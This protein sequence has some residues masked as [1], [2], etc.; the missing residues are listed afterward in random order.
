MPDKAWKAFER[1]IAK[2]LGTHR[3]PLSG[4]ASRHTTSDTLHE[5]LYVEC[6]SRVRSAIHKWWF[7]VRQSALKEYKMPVLALHKKGSGNDLAVISWNYFLLLHNAYW[8]EAQLSE[9]NERTDP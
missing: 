4:G 7:V 1:R 5:E 2:S 9:Q 6:R 8:R 3:T